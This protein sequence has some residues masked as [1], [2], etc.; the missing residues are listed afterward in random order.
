MASRSGL[1]K[2]RRV[3]RRFQEGRSRPPSKAN[4][5][6]ASTR[7]TAASRVRT[8]VIVASSITSLRPGQRTPASD[9]EAEPATTVADETAS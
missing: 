8:Y 5:A 3:R 9:S 7:P 4:R 6:G 1:G 2:T